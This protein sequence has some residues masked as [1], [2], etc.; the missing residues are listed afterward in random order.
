MLDLHVYGQ[1]DT[2]FC[3]DILHIW[4]GTETRA[5]KKQPLSESKMCNVTRVGERTA[6]Q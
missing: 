5:Q 3:L 2:L 6:R 1:I 4:K